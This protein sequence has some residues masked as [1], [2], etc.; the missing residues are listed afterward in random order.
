MDRRREIQ[1][2]FALGR[3]AHTLPQGF[4]IIELVC[5][6]ARTHVRTHVHTCLNSASAPSTDVVFLRRSFLLL[7]FK[8]NQAK[9]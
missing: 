1:L 5:V 8:Y 9:L 4:V 3:G 2:L 7:P 6:C